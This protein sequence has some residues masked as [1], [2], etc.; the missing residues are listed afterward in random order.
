MSQLLLSNMKIRQDADG[1]YCLNDLHKAAGGIGHHQPAKYFATQSAKALISE[2]GELAVAT[3]RGRNG[4]TYVSRELVYAYATWISSSFHLKVIKA[5]DTLQTQ[6]VAVSE[7]AAQDVLDNPLVYMEKLF[8]QAKA[9]DTKN[10]ALLAEKA[11]LEDLN[12]GLEKQN[13]GLQSTV[14]KYEHSV[15]RYAATL[16]GVN[17]MRI[18]ADL[19][20][21]GYLYRKGNTYRVYAKASGLFVE[22]IDPEYGKIEIMVQPAGKAL[23]AQMYQERKLTMKNGY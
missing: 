1:R 23:I 22:K 20:N 9:L 4:G 21:A 7:S 19:M 17:R 5:Y 15:S 10:K 6:G 11:L 8:S 3:R 14:G 13:T 18:K 16:E 2:I 12:F